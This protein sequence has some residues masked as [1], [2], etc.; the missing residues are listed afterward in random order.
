METE[1]LFEQVNLQ[2]LEDWKYLLLISKFGIDEIETKLEII[3]DEYI[4]L[5]DYNPIEHI[6]TRIKTPENIVK[7]LT[8]M[9]VEPTAE[10]AHR[11]LSDIGG[12]RVTCSLIEDIYTLSKLLQN[13]SDLKVLKSKDYVK[14]PK[15]NGSRSYHM[16]LEVPVF[17]T[18]KVLPVKVEVQI[19]T[20]AMDLW[21]SLEHKIYY[22]SDLQIPLSLKA[23]LKHAADEMA[24]IDQELCE[25]KSE[26][27]K[28]V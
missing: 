6:S 8:R 14:N 4:F 24:S 18:D 21:A 26:I 7:K 3:N 5:H 17:L 25:I 27:K 15:P 19:R 10:N 9:G 2:T 22:K 12:V 28:Y 16:I 1:E 13:Q 11:Y 23:R 20:I